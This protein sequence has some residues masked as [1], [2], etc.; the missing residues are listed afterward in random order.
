MLSLETLSPGSWG[1]RFGL[2]VTTLF[3]VGLGVLTRAK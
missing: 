1:I 2:L 3:V